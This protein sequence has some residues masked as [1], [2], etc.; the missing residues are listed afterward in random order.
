[1]KIYAKRLATLAAVGVLTLGAAACGG[2]EEEPAAAAA[3]PAE[4][5]T[6]AATETETPAAAE[7]DIVALASGTPELSTLVSA[8]QAAEL[9]ETLQGEGPFT[10]FA[11]TNDAFAAVGQETLDELLA[12]EGKQQLTD[13]LTY[14][15][16][17]GELKAAD[18]QDGQELETVQGGTL[19]VSVDGDTVRVGDAT[20]A[21]ADVEATNGVVHVID[22][23]LMPPQ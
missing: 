20:V 17:P 10:V 6:P 1:M 13:I 8:V 22:A 15:V 14:H 7:Q 16:V 2:D 23:V 4:T 12:P 3:T 19:Q 5:Q 11:P 18:L 21:M 9:V